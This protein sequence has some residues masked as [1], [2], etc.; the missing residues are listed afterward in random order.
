M[1]RGAALQAGTSLPICRLDWNWEV[2]KQGEINSW[3]EGSSKQQDWELN[4]WSR[5]P[6]ASLAA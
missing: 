5:S 6:A 4:L 2:R 1:S 3:V